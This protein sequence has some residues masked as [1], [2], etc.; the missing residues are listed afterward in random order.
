MPKGQAA[1]SWT[2]ENDAKLLLSIV[3]CAGIS[4]DYNKVAETFGMWHVS[5]SSNIK[6]LLVFT[7]PDVPGSCIQ[8][9]IRNLRKK[10]TGMGMT[11]D[12]SP[13]K[14]TKRSAA[15]ENTDSNKKKKTTDFENDDTVS[16]LF[17]NPT[18]ILC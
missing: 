11:V 8:T 3:S 17:F 13:A 7:G 4:V 1:I 9:R 16:M 5:L 12:E 10:A 15:T 14:S 18:R 6:G 2:P